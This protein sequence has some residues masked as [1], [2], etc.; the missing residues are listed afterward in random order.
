MLHEWLNGEMN[1]TCKSVTLLY[2]QIREFTAMRVIMRSTLWCKL[3]T[4][5]EGESPSL[6]ELEHWHDR[7]P[8]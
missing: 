2:Y 5:G 7:K 4:L 6:S 3:V 8:V 1:G